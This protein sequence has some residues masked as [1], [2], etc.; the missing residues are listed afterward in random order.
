MR[1]MLVV[2]TLPGCSSDQVSLPPNLVQRQH[3][4]TI[5]HHTH[6]TTPPTSFSCHGNSDITAWSLPADVLAET[7]ME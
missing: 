5:A 7:A 2:A 1:G 3:S 4:H 6:T